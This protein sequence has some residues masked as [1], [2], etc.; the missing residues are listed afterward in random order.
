MIRTCSSR[1]LLV[2]VIVAVG[3]ACQPEPDSESSEPH[4]VGGSDV[5]RGRYL[6][7]IGGCNDCHTDGYLQ[8]EGNVPEAQWLLG[9]SLGWQGPWGTT[10]PANLRLTVAGMSEDQW[11]EVMRTRKALPPMPW[12]NLNQMAESDARA[13]YRYL[14][15]LGPA[16]DAAPIAVPPGQEPTTPYMSLAPIVPGQ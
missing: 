16:G 6:A 7:I 3:G 15:S 14:R 13:V 5:E 9:T 4:V 2:A 8:S 1:F 12:M 11:V 10:Y